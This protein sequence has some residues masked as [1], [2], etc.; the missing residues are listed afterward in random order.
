MSKEGSRRKLGQ[1]HGS[2]YYLEKGSVRNDPRELFTAN[3]GVMTNQ[4]P[5]ATLATW[6]RR[7]CH[8]T[9]D[10]GSVKYLASKV[11]DM[12]V[13]SNE[14]PN[15]SKICGICAI[16]RQHKEAGTKTRDKADNIL[17]VVHSD[18]CGPMQTAGLGGERYFITL[19]DER[20]GR[21]GVSLLHTKDG[22]LAAFEGYR[23]R[24]EKSSGRDIKALRSDGGGEY[25]NHR[26]KK[27]LKGAGIQPII[28][29]PYTPSQNGLAERMNRTLMEHARCLLEDAKLDKGFWGYAVLT[30]AH[31]HNRLPSRSHNDISPMEHWTGKIPGVGHL[32]VFGAT[33]WVHIPKERRQKLDPKS[34]KCILVGYEEDPGSRVSRLYDPSR[35]KL[36]LSRDVIIDETPTGI[37]VS[38]SRDTMTVG[39][40]KDPDRALPNARE[41]LEDGFQPLDTIIPPTSNESESQGMQDTITVRPL[42]AHTNIP[43]SGALN[44]PNPG[45][46][47][48]S[49]P[50][51]SQRMRKEN[52]LVASQPEFALLAGN[53][54]AEPQT[55]TEALSSAEKEQWRTPWKAELASLAKDNTWVI[56]KLPEGRSTIGCRW[57]FKKKDDGRYKARLV[58]KGFSQQAGI[59]YEETFAPVAKF[60]T[61][62]IVLA[63]SCENDWEMDGMDVKTA[64]L[65][66]ELDEEIFME[67]PEGVAVPTNKAARGYERPLVCRLRKSIYGLKQAPRAWYSRIYTFFQEHNFIRSDYDHSLFINYEQQ[68][69]LL[70]YVDNLVVAAP[71]R[72]LVD[73]IRDKLHHEF[74]MTDLGPLQTFLGLE[75]E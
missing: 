51:R 35:K 72:A 66:G 2:L 37:S 23:A 32:R 6:H 20:S 70:L 22:T 8:R 13:S 7:L 31:I 36:V 28:S 50:R 68:I 4:S 42:L 75:I 24:A 17:D 34:I 43:Q 19:I 69:I 44:L 39:W 1:R 58:A 27:Y 62:L 26:F 30:A 52:A 64:F 29:P 55:L 38:D 46:Q 48:G 57:L 33:A 10:T 56:E 71:T 21:V 12:E 18:L 53:E 54:T 49:E 3:L 74:E 5:T 61:I 15:T 41:I 14:E 16:G 73:W 11:K 45:G 63:L 40:E 67:I 9:L 65:N 25:V 59:D 47:I 60:T